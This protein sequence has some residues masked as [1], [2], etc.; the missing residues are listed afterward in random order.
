MVANNLINSELID[1][2]YNVIDFCNENNIYIAPQ[3]I[4]SWMDET[5]KS[6]RNKSFIKLINEIKAMKKWFKELHSN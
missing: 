1:D 3:P 5:E 6:S 2:A 4:D